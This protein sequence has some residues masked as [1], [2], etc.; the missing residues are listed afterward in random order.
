MLWIVLLEVALSTSCLVTVT[1]RPSWAIAVTAIWL[2]PAEQGRRRLAPL[3]ASP[4]VV[5]PPNCAMR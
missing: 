3:Q 1:M 5:L 2:S 4:V